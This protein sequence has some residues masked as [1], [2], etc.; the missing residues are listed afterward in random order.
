MSRDFECGVTKRGQPTIIFNNYEFWKYRENKQG[1]VLW[2]CTKAQVF[3]CKATL[4]TIDDAIVAGRETQHTHSGNVANALAR[5]AI[6]EMKQ[7]MTA[8]IAT[9]SSAQGA[10]IASLDGHVQIALPKRASLSRV[11]RRHRQIKAMVQEGGLPP[12]PTD[13]NFVVPE[14]FHQFMLHDTGAGRDRILVFGDHELVSAMS[15]ARL[16]LADGTF[17]VCPTIFFQLYSIHFE[18]MGGI[19]PAGI[20]C[21]LPDKSR[22]TY[23]RLM[24]IVKNLIPH[25]APEIILLDFESAAMNAFHSAFP[26][27]SISGCYFH[28]TQSLLRKV[29]ECGL[30]RD[31]E[32]DN[33]IRSFIRCLPALACVPTEDV[34]VAFD[35]LMEHM[36]ANEKVNEVAT[37]FENT[38][39]R[40]RRLAGRPG[41]V[42]R[43]GQPIFAIASWNHY[44]AAL[45]GIARTN[46][47]VEGWHHSLQSIFMGHHPSMWSFLTGLQ[48]DSQLNKASYLGASAGSVNVGKKIYRDLKARVQRVVGGY[49]TC[50]VITYLRA[51]A[52]LSHA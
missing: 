5:K 40:G 24:G 10:V 32:T 20:Y 50:D 16:W 45:E 7:D 15:R 11:L 4:K 30:K 35:A 49:G 31:Y 38:Y 47:S 19:N 1:Q 22:A 21:L 13:T 37:Y 42:A 33:E 43:F 44:D 27:A 3:H 26:E 41:P 36:P 17:K 23:D 9:P 51:I 8:T 6:G 34:V 28:L 25:A 48:R 14:R 46:N 12:L 39:V 29:G 18:Y 2:R 52:H